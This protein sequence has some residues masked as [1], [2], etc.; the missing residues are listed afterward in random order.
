MNPKIDLIRKTRTK[1]LELI[2][3]LSVP[4]LNKIPEGFNNNIIWNLG[5][6]IAAQEGIFYLRGNLELNIEQG[7]F[8]SFKNGSRPE[9]EINGVEIEKIKSLLFSSLD[10]FESDLQKNIFNSYPAWTTSM[11][12]AINSI[13]DALN[14]LPFHEGLHLGYIIAYKRL[15]S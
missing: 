5:H 8:N 11:G 14:F 6:L 13:E 7:F 15:I 9:R 1:A 3:G 10:Q 2:S 4:E 12:I